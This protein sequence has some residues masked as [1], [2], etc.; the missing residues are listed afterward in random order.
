[1]SDETQEPKKAAPAAKPAKKKS[2]VKIGAPPEIKKPIAVS[3][4][5]LAAARR[6]AKKSKKD[7]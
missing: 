6:E 5:A 4:A 7:G 3:N 1:M 2:E